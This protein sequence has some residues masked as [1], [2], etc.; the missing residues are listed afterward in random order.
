MATVMSAPK[1][2]PQKRGLAI[3]PKSVT[4]AYL[5]AA[6]KEKSFLSLFEALQELPSPVPQDSSC[7]GAFVENNV[8]VFGV[9][10]EKAGLFSDKVAEPVEVSLSKI[11]VSI[12]ATI[13]IT[14]EVMTR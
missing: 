7:V 3:S 1:S 13:A 10:E 6:I 12:P 14:I 5:S 4:K 9:I 8:L 2:S 11:L